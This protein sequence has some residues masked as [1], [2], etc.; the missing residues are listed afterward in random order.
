MNKYNNILDN[1]LNKLNN[2]L[3]NNDDTFLT[4]LKE[5][6]NSLLFGKNIKNVK[7]LLLMLTRPPL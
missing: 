3:N 4:T 5:L 7:K 1:L 2:I 6:Y